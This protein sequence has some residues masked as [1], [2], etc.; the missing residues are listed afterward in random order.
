MPNSLPTEMRVLE[1]SASHDDLATA[2]RGLRVVRKHVPQPRRGQ[3]LV[4]MAAAPCNP[5]DTLFLQG[6]YG[7]RKLLPAAPGWEGAGTVVASGGGWL[8]NWMLGRRVACGGQTDGDGTW[9]EYYVC[10]AA[11]CAP[12]RRDLD[13]DQAACLLVN[14]LTAWAL[15]ET[16]RRGRHR[17]AIQT[18]AASQLGRMIIRLARH[19][20]L[21]LIAAV[22]RGAQIDELKALGAPHVLDIESPGFNDELRRLSAKL[23][24]TIAFDAIA[25]PM[26]G[27]LLR[28]MPPRSAVL[29][30]G[31][32]SNHNCSDLDPIDLLFRD[33]RV[34]GFY[35]G[36]WIERQGLLRRLRL[37][38]R[39]QALVVAGVLTTTIAHRLTYDDVPGQLMACLQ[40]GTAGKVLIVPG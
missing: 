24:A 30:Y 5:S 10:N 40:S 37:V 12:L 28:A 4:Q 33:Q 27:R 23:G 3:V 1:L 13:F 38:R 25:G 26:P 39:V 6:R 19:L 17:A 18:A 31:A 2:V 34:E 35:L 9:A 32:L 16:A 14:P 11:R 21:P 22:R 20:G 7:V 8:A 29:V 15:V 36:N